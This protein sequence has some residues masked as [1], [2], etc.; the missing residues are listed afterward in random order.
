MVTTQISI[1]N[2]RTFQ[3]F[4]GHFSLFPGQVAKNSRTSKE[5]Y[6]KSKKITISILVY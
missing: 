6:S 4:P 3:D 1:L 2:S 5:Q